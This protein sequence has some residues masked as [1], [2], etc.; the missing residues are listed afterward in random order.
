MDIAP[1]FIT[2]FNMIQKFL[3]FIFAIA[4][5]VPAIQF[6]TEILPRPSLFRVDIEREVPK[7]SWL[8][9]LEGHYQLKLDNWLVQNSGLFGLLTKFNNTLNYRVFGLGSANYKDDTIVG[10]DY[11]LFDRIYVN[12]LNGK[13]ISTTDHLHK[14]ALIL[15]RLQ[16]HLSK[17]N[18]P[19]LLVI[20]PNKAVLNPNWI[21]WF[22]R[23]PAPE[24]RYV[25]RLRPLLDKY[26]INY[27]MVG[28][29]LPKGSPYFVKSG[30]HFNDL[31]KCLSAKLV[32]DRLAELHAKPWSDFGCLQTG[33]KAPESEDLDLSNLLNV[34]NPAKSIAAV[35]KIEINNLQITAEKISIA[36]YGTSYLFGLVDMFDRTKAFDRVDF[37]FYDAT[38]YYSRNKKGPTPQYGKKKF[39]A[40]LHSLRFLENHDVIILESTDARLH[41]LGFGLLEQL[42]KELP[43]QPDTELITE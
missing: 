35:P 38:H 10:R 8:D 3:C 14:H 9:F 27:L 22:M 43:L 34:W 25:E 29:Q 24:L 32:R 11:A 4:L 36:F 31:A 2:S 13:Y 28:E 41:Q 23:S 1:F 5:L 30:A 33:E 42:A 18:K 12:D 39:E 40:R 16:D 19:F 17:L 15:R 7:F 26:K 6:T 20:H 21:S 37:I